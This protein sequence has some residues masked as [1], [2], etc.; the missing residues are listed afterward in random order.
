MIYYKLDQQT[1][2]Y[3]VNYH[4]LQPYSILYM[5]ILLCV[6]VYAARLEREGVVHQAT[7]GGRLSDKLSRKPTTTKATHKTGK[8][9]GASYFIYQYAC[10]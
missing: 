5:Y 3:I 7:A 10:S 6:Y 1:Q 2:C 9:L 8:V 4:F